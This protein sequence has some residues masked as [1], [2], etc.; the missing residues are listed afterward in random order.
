MLN[1]ELPEAASVVKYA[2]ELLTVAADELA[3]KS[4]DE[5]PDAV[6]VAK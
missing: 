3:N 4:E 1:E 2:A 6:A 5:T